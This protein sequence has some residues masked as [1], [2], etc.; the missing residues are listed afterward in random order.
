MTRPAKATY[1]EIRIARQ[2]RAQGKTY[3]FIAKRLG[4]SLK[5]VWTHARQATRPQEVVTGPPRAT[6]NL[7]RTITRY[8]DFPAFNNAPPEL[9]RRILNLAQRGFDVP[10]S[11]LGE[12]EILARAGMTLDERRKS[13]RLE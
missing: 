2:L 13:L 5:F 6:T 10:P 1:R 3:Q 9:Q 12:W 11:K 7:R 8:R 4:R